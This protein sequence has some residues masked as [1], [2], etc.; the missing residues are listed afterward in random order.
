MVIAAEKQEVNSIDKDKI[1][2]F[3]PKSICISMVD[4][5]DGVTN[6][7]YSICSEL[8]KHERRGDG[9]SVVV[10][11]NFSVAKAIAIYF[12]DNIVGVV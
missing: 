8:S 4:K 5:L 12:V 10:T 11:A 7:G 9:S 2:S 1:R 6:G 3:D